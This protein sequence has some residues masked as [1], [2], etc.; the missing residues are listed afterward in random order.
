MIPEEIF[1]DNDLYIPE[2]PQTTTNTKVREAIITSPQ[3]YTSSTHL[4]VPPQRKHEETAQQKTTSNISGYKHALPLNT[5]IKNKTDPRLHG[6]KTI[7]SA[8]PY[9]DFQCQRF[10]ALIIYQ[11]SLRATLT[12]HTLHHTRRAQKH[13]QDSSC[14]SRHYS[15]PHTPF[16]HASM[17]ISGCF[18]AL[19]NGPG[20]HMNSNL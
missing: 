5:H 12:L 13:T 10:L 19:P 14:L 20:T 1:I 6:C 8:G 3:P 15:D 7:S 16:Y 4:L 18:L 2:Y 17:L 11:L 9:I